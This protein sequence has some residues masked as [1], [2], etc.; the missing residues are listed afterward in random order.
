MTGQVG[1]YSDT[2][3]VTLLSSSSSSS[4][5][6]SASPNLVLVYD[7]SK[8][9]ANNT[10]SV[11]L[12]GTV[13]ARIDWGDGTWNTYTTTGFKTHTYASPGVYTVE[14]SGS[15]T[16]LDHGTGTSSQNNK[17][18]LVR[19]LSFG[20]IGITSMLR[21]FRGCSNL[22]QV[23]PSLPAGV[24]NCSEMFRECSSFNDSSVAGWSTSSVTNMSAMFRDCPAFNVDLSSWSTESVTNMN[25]MFYGCAVFN[26]DLSSWNTG[27]VLNMSSMFYNADAYQSNMSSW[28]LAK[29]ATSAGLDN[30]M[31]LAT[32]LSRANYD[33]TL[34]GWDASKSTWR[35]DLRPN[36]G[37]SVYTC[38]S[39]ADAARSALVAYGWTVTD[40]GCAAPAVAEAKVA[41]G[42]GSV[43]DDVICPPGQCCNDTVFG[44]DCRRC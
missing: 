20:Q 5:S 13:N 4:S 39:A 10:I 19:C 14:V 42:A 22:V 43:C 37:G 7:T 41:E 15:M 24:T 23:P 1:P 28:N 25:S 16:S 9:P 26:A 40:G 2:T 38:G 33:A 12:A 17:L 18:K 44:F 35:N 6:S 27:S 11:P 8:E 34:V 3:C 31:A 29:I 32:G 30:F 21:G 36:F